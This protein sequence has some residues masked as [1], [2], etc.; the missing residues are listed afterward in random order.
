MIFV[1][2]KI[3]YSKFNRGYKFE[4]TWKKL[5]KEGVNLIDK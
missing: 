1:G 2:T 5:N 4:E 3:K